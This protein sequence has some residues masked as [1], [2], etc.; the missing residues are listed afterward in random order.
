MNSDNITVPTKG[1]LITGADWND[2]INMYHLFNPDVQKTAPTS[3]LLATA[4]Y[5]NSF[6]LS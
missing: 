1:N 5:F 2:Y 6:N 4:Q 3:G